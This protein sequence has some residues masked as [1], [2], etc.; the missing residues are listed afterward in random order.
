M[1]TLSIEHMDKP[2]IIMGHQTSTM[3]SFKTYSK[4]IAILLCTVED[5]GTCSMM[6][7]T[8]LI[9]HCYQSLSNTIT[10][11][12]SRIIP[13]KV[14]LLNSMNMPIGIVT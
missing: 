11:L 14:I 8:Q 7:G 13:I 1:N 2:C 12:V 9:T 10:I 4:N 6:I 5:T 3:S